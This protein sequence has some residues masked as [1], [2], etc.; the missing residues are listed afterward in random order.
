MN[1]KILPLLFL[2]LSFSVA[3]AQTGSIKGTIVDAASKEAII[4]AS[5]FLK[6]STPPVGAA[7]DQDGKFDIT[8][9]ATG[10]H[11]V[12]VSYISYKNKEIEVTV[13]PNQAVLINATLEEDVANL[14][15]VKIVGQRQTFTDVSVITE[16]KK[17]EQIAVGISAQQIQKSQDRD[18]SQVVRRV[19]GVSIQDDRFVIIRG[20]NERYNTV[21]LNDAITPSS[22]V[23]VK[24]FSFDLIPSSAIDRIMIYKSGAPELPG[25]F[26]GGV[27][28]IYTKTV[29]DENGFT[30]NLST[31]YRSAT[32]FRD[33]KDYK[34]SSLDWLGF[35]AKDRV[36]PSNFPKTQTIINENTPSD[37]TLN[38]FRNLTDFYNLQTKTIKPD[39]RFSVGFNRN[40][41]IGDRKLTTFNNINYTH[42]N[43]YMPT[44]QF[45]YLAY[46]D[47]TKR[48][49]I[50]LNYNDQFFGQNTRLG[51]MSNWGYIINPNHKIEFRNLFNQLTNKET[52]FRQGYSTDNGREVQNYA[53]R[54]ESKSIYSGQLSG[55]HDVSD[56]TTIKWTGAFGWTHRDEPDF[57]RFVSSRNIGST[58][59][60]TIETL[61]GSGASLTRNARFFSK[62]NEYSSSFR[63]DIEHRIDRSGYEGDEK[64]QIKLRAGGMAEYKDRVFSARWFNLNNPGGVSSEILNSAPEQFFSKSNIAA[65]KLYYVEHTNTDD[66]YKAQNFLAAGYV[67]AFIPFSAKFNASVGFRGEFNRQKLQSQE[68]GSG[69]NIRVNN[70]IFRALPSVN[71]AYNFSEK[72]LLRLAYSITLNRPEFRELAPF[73]YYDFNFD[74]SRVGNPNL[75]T[76]SIQNVDLRYEF[77]PKEGEVI[78]VAGFYKGFKNP[79]ESR[80]RYSG[81]GVT[82]TVD[83]A[84]KAY[85]Y[86]AE[87]EIRKSLKEITTSAFIDNLTFLFNASVIKSDVS[88]GF[89]GQESNRQL[90]GQSPFLINT[91]LYYTEPAIG[92]QI[93]ALYNVIGKRIFLVGDNAVQ[94]TVYEMPR[95]VIDLNIIKAIGRRMELKIGVQDLLNQKFRLIQDSNLDGKITSV[96]ESYQKY[97]RGTYSTVGLTYKF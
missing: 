93:N 57:R 88:T 32:T 86:G 36:L 45:R 22:E 82:F 44:E 64:M 78:S 14:Q 83:N 61:Q 92:L 16:I 35:G 21:M 50:Q 46:S 6:G 76:P 73:N 80:I 18:A 52:T 38:A 63:A 68:R 59:P 70:P 72:S 62:L 30:L 56:A 20:L 94:P 34:G 41:N 79:I 29:P 2:I 26:A 17:A 47:S 74:V 87:V 11:T 31:S 8:G 27:I 49:E 9:I 55:T 43:Q 77:Y 15:E 97:R 33:A 67:G 71:L 37:R 39:L 60:F 28:K 65:D 89:T 81:S 84:K 53:F 5:V 58:G 51:A 19:P 48:S 12:L 24:S 85:A 95:N 25:E 96:D 3:K 1:S 91:G 66:K 40:M 4:G 10:K 13:Y 75:K 69:V 54:Y 42:T 90:Q 7:T 23:D